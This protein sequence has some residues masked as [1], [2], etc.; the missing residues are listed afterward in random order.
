MKNSLGQILAVIL[1]LAVGGRAD[2]APGE[3]RPVS[4]PAAATRPADTATRPTAEDVLAAE[5]LRHS[6][7]ELISAPAIAGPNRGQSQGAAEGA[8]SRL[9]T[10]LE[11]PSPARAGRILVLAEFAARLDRRNSD[12]CRLLADIYESQDAPARAAA[13]LDECV[14]AGCADQELLLRWL[15]LKLGGLDT[16]E[17]RIAF[18]KGL[19]DD[20]GMPPAFRAQ[21]AAEWGG[22]LARQGKALP[23]SE[24]FARA[25]KL[26]GGNGLA[27]GGLMS[28]EANPAPRRLAELLLAQLRGSPTDF[29]VG[30]ELAALLDSLGLAAESLEVFDY[31]WTAFLM[32]SPQSDSPAGFV[33]EYCSAMLDAGRADDVVETFEPLLPH[34]ALNADLYSLLV[35]AHRAL[36]QEGKA[37]ELIQVMEAKYKLLANVSSEPGGTD[38]A[39]LAWFH[40]FTMSDPATAVGYANRALLKGE[41]PVAERVLGAADLVTGAP[42]NGVARLEKLAKHDAYAAAYLAEYCFSVG[43]KPAAEQALQAGAAVSRGGP[44]FRKLLAVAGSHGAEIPELSGAAE[45]RRAFEQSDRRF[46][47]AARRPDRFVAVTIRPPAGKVHAGE[48]LAVRVVLANTS[49]I[50]LPLGQLGFLNADLALRATIDGAEKAEFDKLPLAVWQAGRWLDP[51]KSLTC[52]ARLD[53]GPLG[54]FLAARPFETLNITVAGV[55]DPIGRG[56]GVTSALPGVSIEPVEVTREGIVVWSASA[57]AGSSDDA[58]QLA[59]GRIVRDLRHGDLPEAVAA[60][61]RIA[62]LLE[63]AGL[64]SRGQAKAP[65]QLEGRFSRPVL[66]SLLRAALEHHSPAVRAQMLAEL[67]HT[68]LDAGILMLLPASIDDPSPLVRLRAAELIGV[69]R[70]AGRQAVLGHLAQDGDSLVKRMASLFLGSASQGAGGAR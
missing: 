14:K 17:Q 24:A 69:S 34:F 25:L 8:T 19:C 50:P 60:A 68:E 58:Y 23:A 51:G 11:A 70:S 35:E 57:P 32:R 36:G 29:P 67:G 3:G 56:G 63:F 10:T 65:A 59:L 61:R 49:D 7:A 31:S 12:T 47:Q 13:A 9:A 6:A 26:D 5:E 55:L 52:E 33:V 2:L 37:N 16:A 22:V 42:A 46:M 18:L 43:D 64:V 40:L 62:S 45:V 28:V 48:P 44:A 38:P 66:L 27:L 20:E 4:G 54:R 53:A 1:L 39:E 41:S 15:G 21:A 30:W